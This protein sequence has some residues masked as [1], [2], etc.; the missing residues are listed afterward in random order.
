MKNNG[1]VVGVLLWY[2]MNFI[3]LVLLDCLVVI[4]F[5]GTNLFISFREDEQW[6]TPGT[7]SLKARDIQFQEKPVHLVDIDY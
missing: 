1:V 3:R 5:K 2:F 7:K 4:S 6:N